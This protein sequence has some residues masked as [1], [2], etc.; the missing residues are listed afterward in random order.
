MIIYNSATYCHQVSQ[1]W[2]LEGSTSLEVTSGFS[3][4]S[5]WGSHHL[6]Q[7]TAWFTPHLVAGVLV[8]GSPND[9][10]APLFVLEGEFTI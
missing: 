3:L 7:L 9:A 6:G 4:L 1:R 2:I 10:N 8:P 5:K